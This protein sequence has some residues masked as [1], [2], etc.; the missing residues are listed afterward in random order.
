C[1]VAGVSFTHVALSVLFI[2]YSQLILRELFYN[3]PDFSNILLGMIIFLAKV[4]NP[5]ANFLNQLPPKSIQ[6]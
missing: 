4:Q 3:L 5:S 1:Q 2:V 6:K